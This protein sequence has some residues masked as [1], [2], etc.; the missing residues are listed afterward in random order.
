MKLTLFRQATRRFRLCSDMTLQENGG[1]DD[2]DGE[3]GDE[4]G[5]LGAL[6]VFDEEPELPLKQM[7]GHDLCSIK[8]QTLVLSEFFDDLVS[9]AKESY[10]IIFEGSGIGIVRGRTS[11]SPAWK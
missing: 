6:W 8:N 7:W 10:L 9:E 1:A 3:A 4:A 11:S 2:E 5:L